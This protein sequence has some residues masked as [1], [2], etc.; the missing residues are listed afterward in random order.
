[1]HM[2]GFS[3]AVDASPPATIE[4]ESVDLLAILELWTR[5]GAAR[6]P[7]PA[8]WPGAGNRHVPCRDLD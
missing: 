1:M 2:P 3:T 8:R 6:D 4:T 7:R 5:T